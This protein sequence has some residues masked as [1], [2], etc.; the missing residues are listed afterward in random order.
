MTECKRP[1]KITR[2]GLVNYRLSATVVVW[3]LLRTISYTKNVQKIVKFVITADQGNV[4]IVENIGI[5]VD[6]YNAKLTCPKH[7]TDEG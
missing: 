2:A 1:E 3:F 5:V 6:A 7:L 4:Q